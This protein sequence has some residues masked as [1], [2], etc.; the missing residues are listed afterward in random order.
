MQ[1]PA[2]VVTGVL[3]NIQ[4]NNTALLLDLHLL[5]IG[6]EPLPAQ[7][8]VWVSRLLSLSKG[9]ARISNNK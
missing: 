3:I 5:A 8:Q 7:T 2:Q 1:H 9:S 4:R 6:H